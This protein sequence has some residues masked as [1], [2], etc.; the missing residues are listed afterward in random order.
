MEIS[1]A[2]ILGKEVEKSRKMLGLPVPHEIV[3]RR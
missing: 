2:F 3:K 1:A